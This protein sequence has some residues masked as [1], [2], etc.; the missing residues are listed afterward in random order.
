MEHMMR[1]ELACFESSD[2]I[3]HL[4]TRLRKSSGQ[5]VQKSMGEIDDFHNGKSCPAFIR[6]KRILEFV[7]EPICIHNFCGNGS[8]LRHWH[9]K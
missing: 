9:T 5:T 1:V 8:H 6:S 2:T 4:R 7:T 3:C